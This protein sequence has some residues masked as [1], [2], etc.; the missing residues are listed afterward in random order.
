MIKTED[1]LICYLP[2]YSPDYN[3]IKLT[4]LVLK[5]W[6]RQNYCFIQP[7]YANFG[8]FLSSVIELSRCDRFTREQ[9]RHAV[10]DV[11]IEQRVLDSIH[12]RIK[13]YERGVIRDAELVELVEQADEDVREKEVKFKL[14][15]IRTEYT[16]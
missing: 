11:Y 5:A 2:S 6:I 16:T 12:E 14:N 15:I 8:G 13:V 9:F 1:H 3:P 7:A 10:G 4:F